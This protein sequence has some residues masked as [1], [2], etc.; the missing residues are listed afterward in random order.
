MKSFSCVALTFSL[1]LV[2]CGGGGGGGEG[3][4]ASTPNSTQQPASTQTN[5]N[6]GS[7]TT[8]PISTTQSSTP[9]TATPQTLPGSTPTAVPPA[10]TPVVSQPTENVTPTT[11]ANAEPFTASLTIAPADGAILSGIVT[12]EVRGT[13]IENVEL[14]PASDYLP[15]L[16]F[17][18][19]TSDKTVA[20]FNFDTTAIPNRDVALRISAFNGSPGSP[21]AQEIV[22]MPPRTW[23]FRNDPD[24]FGSQEGRALL[25]KNAGRGYTDPTSA[26]PVVC[27]SGIPTN[28][29]I[30]PEQ[31]TGRVDTGFVDPADGLIV[32]RNGTRVNARWYCNAAASPDGSFGS[33]CVCLE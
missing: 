28:P 32:L 33:E 1:L 4:N 9:Q 22:V 17:F 16:G 10:T 5:V 12:L 2:G 3:T 27:I 31:C 21:N 11:G 29:P 8:P 13:G 23:R 7:Q 30:P 6:S 20:R 14:L 19:V 24:P 15:I 26:L 18:T 25:C